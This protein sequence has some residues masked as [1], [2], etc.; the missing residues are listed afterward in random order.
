MLVHTITLPRIVGGP[1]I[2]AKALLPHRTDDAVALSF[3]GVVTVTEAAIR[4]AV[5]TGTNIATRPLYLLD[6]NPAIETAVGEFLYDERIFVPFVRLG[7]PPTPEPGPAVEVP[8]VEPVFAYAWTDHEWRVTA[9]AL[10]ADGRDP[11]TAVLADRL[12]SSL[13][14][15]DDAGT[16]WPT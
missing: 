8:H 15:P 3:K 9:A 1:S 2:V 11:L 12:R 16:G 10:E 13:V 4:E 6:T 5:M 14:K 7:L